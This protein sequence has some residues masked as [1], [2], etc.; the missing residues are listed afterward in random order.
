MLRPYRTLVSRLSAV[1]S[2][3][4]F[5]VTASALE[6]DAQPAARGP[7]RVSAALGA[8]IAFTGFDDDGHW[9]DET[10]PFVVEAGYHYAPLRWLDVGAGAQY[11]ELGDAGG[12]RTMRQRA[13]LPWL[14]ARVHT[15]GD[16]VEVGVSLRAG[17]YV[18]WLTNVPDDS[19]DGARTHTWI[20]KH[21]ALRPDVRWWVSPSFAIEVAPSLALGDASDTQSVRGSYVKE[22]AGF[23]ALTA[24]AGVVF[25]PH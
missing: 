25:A 5:A 22:D 16:P 15:T 9:D 6:T 1:G 19:G 20:G 17:A 14:G 7:H 24:V 10:T 2:V 23:A 12:W 11:L 3:L 4:A 18:L 21:V 8:G 13:L